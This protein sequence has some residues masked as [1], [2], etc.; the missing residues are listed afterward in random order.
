MNLR[1]HLLLPGLLT[2][3]LSGLGHPGASA[4]LTVFDAPPG[5]SA[6][7]PT[8][9]NATGDVAGYYFANGSS[10]FVLYASAA[11][12]TPFSLYACP[13][14]ESSLD[15]WGIN[16]SDM[17]VGD[18]Y[19]PPGSTSSKAF[20][21][22]APCTSVTEIDVPGSGV[23]SA[24]ALNASGVVA[25]SWSSSKS[26][27]HAFGFVR[28]A[29]GVITKFQVPKPSS[30]VTVVVTQPSAV[31]G[32]GD[33]AG[34]FV[35]STNAYHVFVRGVRGGIVTY[36]VPGS[37]NITV[38][39]INN[40]GEIVGHYYD[41]TNSHGFLITRSSGGTSVKT[42]DYPGATGTAPSAVN[43]GGTIVGYYYVGSGPLQAF[44]LD[45]A[46]NFSNLAIA[47]ATTVVA[48]SINDTGSITGFFT[49]AIGY[50][51]FI[52]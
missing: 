23:V 28:S 6:I 13:G 44:E 43:A 32:S 5:A 21:C 29:G 7:Y 36:D 17:I 24:P 10:G 9:I 33:I 42:F 16:A 4:A 41:G 52:L 8:S 1:R 27:S 14:C 2:C 3:A 39:G 20:L 40:R 37:T 31:N 46:G 25:G 38:T 49:D 34:T 11:A 12:V 22:A 51:G 26:P 48:M 35:D 45:A 30:T 18:G 47:G 19:F 50:H 15:V